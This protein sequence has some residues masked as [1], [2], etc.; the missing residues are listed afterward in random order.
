MTAVSFARYRE[1]LVTYLRPQGFKVVLLALVLLSNVALQ[2]I[3]PQFLRMF[4]D[5]VG[6]KSSL[7]TLLGFA[8]LFLVL[9]AI[10]YTLNIAQ[11]YLSENVGWTATNALRVDLATH[12]LHLDLSFHNAH[13]PGELIERVDGDINSLFTILS[14]QLFRVL[15]H[16]LLLLGVLIALYFIDWRV[17]TGL[18]MFGAI[19]LF[20][21]SCLRNFATHHWTSLHHARAEL[22]GFLE[23]HLAGTED[24]RSAGAVAYTMHALYRLM[25]QLWHKHRAA[26][27]RGALMQNITITMFSL[28]TALSLILG[29][30]LFSAGMITLGTVFLI[31]QYFRLLIQ[32][33]D[34]MV[35]EVH[36][37]QDANACIQRIDELYCIKSAL[38]EKGNACLPEGA[39]SLAVEHVSF[40]YHEGQQVLH[41]LSFRLEPGR[42][43]G[44]LGHTGSGKTTLTRLLF[45]LYEPTTGAISLGDVDIRLVGQRDLRQKVALVTQDVQIF[46]AS[47]RDNL[48]FFDRSISHER[49]VQAL[50]EVGL[51]SW[52]N[53]L[54]N[55][56]E[57]EM[58]SGGAGLS[59]GEAQLLA[60]T[61]VFLK[62]PGLVIL[63]E[64]TSRL[65]PVTERLIEHATTR[66]LQGRTAIII[67]HRLATVGSVDELLI[68]ENG[69]IREQGTRLQLAN[70]PH[71]VFAHLLHTGLEEVLI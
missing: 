71:S 67:A 56:L 69:C 15:S 57:T 5:A 44:L 65:D 59:A 26:A 55:G 20:V 38:E 28:G 61:R 45:H 3:N 6:N 40:G 31:F 1:L 43:L 8:I 46:Q 24:I 23:E 4:I 9:A 62:N 13:T 37:L 18:T 52:Y 48:T 22:S 10:G 32:P 21:L 27:I 60:L 30:Y 47:V 51:E 39:L 63:D 36:S 42:V 17:G 49:I 34:G 25:R 66:L 12:L 2:L 7:S 19:A 70:D 50:R 14:S 33:L 53:A 64:A 11:T 41:D 58:A 16:I 68:L 29:T 54:P 35:Q